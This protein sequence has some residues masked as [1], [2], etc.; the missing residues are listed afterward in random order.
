MLECLPEPD[1][2]VDHEALSVASVRDRLPEPGIEELD[3]IRLHVAVARGPLHRP[4]LTLHVHDDGSGPVVGDHA[5]HFVVTKARD[6]VHDLSTCFEGGASDG[7]LAGVDRD[8]YLSCQTFHD[9]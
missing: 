8:R 5:P 2:R 4:R 6:V 9:R 7:G 3:D 1:A